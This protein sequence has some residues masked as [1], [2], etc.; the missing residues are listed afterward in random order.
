[1]AMSRNDYAEIQCRLEA[2]NRGLGYMLNVPGP[3][4][5]SQFIVDPQIR[6]Q[7]FGA[8]VSMNIVNINS[9][10][11]GLNQTLQGHDCLHKTN[12]NRSTNF[13]SNYVP[14]KFP[15]YYYTWTEQPRSINPA[16]EIRGLENNRFDFPIRNP[17]FDIERDKQ[18]N[19][20]TRDISKS[21]WA[22]NSNNYNY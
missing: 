22:L 10:L 14:L 2:E 7:E 12:I 13:N 20:C 11:K 9:E 4:Q 15:N 5:N 19:L 18:N 16:W 3:L 6:L 17:Q 21:S 1:M 8:N